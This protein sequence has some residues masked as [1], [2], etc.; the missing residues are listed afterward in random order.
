MGLIPG[1]GRYAGGGHRNPLQYSCLENPRDRRALQA[2][3][4]GVLKSG[5]GLSDYTTTMGV[6]ALSGVS[7][8][9]RQLNLPTVGPTDPGA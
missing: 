9:Q 6:T 4:H 3:V 1:W 8:H 5:T 7:R 2:T